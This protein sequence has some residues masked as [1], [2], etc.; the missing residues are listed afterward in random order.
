MVR[1]GAFTATAQVQ[2]LVL[3]T[4]NPHEAMAEKKKVIL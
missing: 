1:I 2:S 4:E 3:G